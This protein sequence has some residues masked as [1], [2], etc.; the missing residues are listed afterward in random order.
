MRAVLKAIRHSVI[1]TSAF[2]FSQQAGEE[3]DADIIMPPEPIVEQNEV[4]EAQK[5]IENK[6]DEGAQS[7][8]VEP[9]TGKAPVS[10]RLSIDDLI[11]ENERQCNP[12]SGAFSSIYCLPSNQ[13]NALRI[14]PSDQFGNLFGK[15]RVAKRQRFNAF[16]CGSV[17]FP[18]KTGGENS[19]LSEAWRCIG[20][21][22]IIGG[23][24]WSLKG[25]AAM[26]QNMQDTQNNP[27]FGVCP[28]GDIDCVGFGIEL[29]IEN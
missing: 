28:E 26:K 11:P 13:D 9:K 6:Q 24:K 19:E 21:V 18:S 4:V 16:D 25:S 12:L 27:R 5:P 2:L 8:S 20:N 14:D 22:D 1:A 10:L 29:R 3:I 17:E 23:E 7:A 15:D